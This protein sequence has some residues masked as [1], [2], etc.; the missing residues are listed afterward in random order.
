[1]ASSAAL[2]VFIA[3]ERQ[4]TVI[5]IKL[6]TSNSLYSGYSKNITKAMLRAIRE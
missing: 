4:K 6:K 3:M 2:I 5:R 1:M